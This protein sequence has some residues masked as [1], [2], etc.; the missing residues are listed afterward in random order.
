MGIGPDVIQR[1]TDA[2]YAA[3]MKDLTAQGFSVQ[4]RTSLMAD[5][6]FA[7]TKSDPNPDEN[8]SGAGSGG[9]CAHSAG[10]T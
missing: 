3:L 4:D 1:I 7:A 8:S 6:T 10:R 5:A 9:V 2:A